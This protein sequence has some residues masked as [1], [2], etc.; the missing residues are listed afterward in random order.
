MSYPLHAIATLLAPAD[1]TPGQ[2]IS[3]AA[4]AQARIATPGGALLAS[5]PPGTQLRPGQ[6]VQVKHGIAYP[7]PASGPAYQL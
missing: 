4:N 1:S 7:V 5:A 3:A 6:R 2:V